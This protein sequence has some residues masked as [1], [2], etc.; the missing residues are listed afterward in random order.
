MTPEERSELRLKNYNHT[1]DPVASALERMNYV[2]E[3][4]WDGLLREEF[5]RRAP[6]VRV[7]RDF[8]LTVE[9]NPANMTYEY[10]VDTP[11]GLF[12]LRSVPMPFINTPTLDEERFVEKAARSLAT[13]IER[14]ILGRAEVP[15]SEF[16]T[17][18]LT[19]H[20]K[21]TILTGGGWSRVLEAMVGTGTPRGPFLLIVGR[22][23]HGS[24]HGQ[25]TEPPAKSVEVSMFTTLLEPGEAVLASLTADSIR[26]VI[27]L[28]S[29][30]F[31]SLADVKRT[32]G[33][34]L[35]VVCSIA[36]IVLG[37]GDDRRDR[38]VV[39]LTP[40]G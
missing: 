31:R 23:E 11:D 26:L 4:K 27:A 1:D 19:T 38:G 39:H 3:P 13:S 5:D 14:A 7:L 18:G 17:W 30:C 2:H 21:R 12:N 34:R 8:G 20:P 25:L 9:A 10:R 16:D 33:N 37:I 32:N 40:G 35:K 24:R 22:G 36:P 29:T 6:I 15:P 28:E